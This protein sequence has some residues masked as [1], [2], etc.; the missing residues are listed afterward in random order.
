VSARARRPRRPA[1]HVPGIAPGIVLWI[2]LGFALAAAPWAA[3]LAAAQPPAG[4]TTEGSATPARPERPG[5]PVI[6]TE[7]IGTELDAAERALY[8]FFPGVQAFRGAQVLV[9]DRPGRYTLE[10]RHERD[11]RERR[12]RT[13]LAA[14]DLERL[15]IHARLVEAAAA[16]PEPDAAGAAWIRG[17]ALRLAARREYAA[18]RAVAEDLRRRHPSAADSAW[19]EAFPRELELLSEDP[20]APLLRGAGLDQSGRV[21]LLIFSGYYGIWLGVATPI[22]VREESAEAIAAGLLFGG[23]ASV[24]LTHL[25]TRGQPMPRGRAST[26]ALGGH[27]GTWQGL[28]WSARADAESR[29]TLKAGLFGGL[30]GIGTAALATRYVE[31]GEGAAELFHWSML[32]GAWFGAL[33]PEIAERDPSGDANLAGALIGSDAAALAAILGARHL[34]VSR[35]RVRLVSL[36]GILG[37]VAGAGLAVLA[38]AEDSR[39]ILLSAG[40]GSVA[41]LFA[42]G[43]LT[44]GI[45]AP[46][47][48]SR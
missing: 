17:L 44:R 38:N 1:G 32:Y 23:G 6:W 12:V 40:A 35:T 45:D 14:V 29:R 47:N 36:S 46:G 39:T 19:A 21:E 34:P 28:G 3:P 24:Y 8:G 5:E 20:P 41:G 9:G 25:L 11:G 7:A 26:I 27:L 4:E 37:G 48:G 15:R 16:A 33:A 10:Y 18:A 13:G 31:V 43:W 2:A 22:A 30:A 42:G